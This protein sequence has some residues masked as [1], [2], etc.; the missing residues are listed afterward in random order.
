MLMPEP[1]MVEA[2]CDKA[3]LA[4]CILD[5][6]QQAEDLGFSDAASLLRRAQAMAERA[7]E[8]SRNRR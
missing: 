6:A 7:A 1:S 2:D 8:A 3:R 4:R 5:A